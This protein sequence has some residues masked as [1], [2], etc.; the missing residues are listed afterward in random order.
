M[1]YPG[2]TT[3]V[4]KNRGDP[5]KVKLTAPY[6]FWFH[7]ERRHHAHG[8]RHDCALEQKPTLIG[9]LPSSC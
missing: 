7:A 9:D 4:S 5:V 1:C 3:P 8:D 2:V 6:K